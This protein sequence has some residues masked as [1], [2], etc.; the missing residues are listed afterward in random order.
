MPISHEQYMRHPPHTPWSCHMP[1]NIVE[2]SRKQNL[3]LPNLILTSV[4]SMSSLWSSF[5]T[6][7]DSRIISNNIVKNSSRVFMCC[8]SITFRIDPGIIIRQHC[9]VLDHMTQIF[10]SIV[11]VSLQDDLLHL[12]YV[13]TECIS[14][15][16]LVPAW[17]GGSHNLFQKNTNTTKQQSRSCRKSS[18]SVILISFK[19]KHSH[20]HIPRTADLWENSW[21]LCFQISNK[22]YF[23]LYFHCPDV[24]PCKYKCPDETNLETKSITSSCNNPNIDPL[25]TNTNFQMKQ[26]WRT[27]CHKFLQ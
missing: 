19:R 26:I 4:W 2:F 10:K 27:K 21:A 24:I 7:T 16:T 23:L 6:S 20:H 22:S 15:A 14:V 5:L 25:M 3:N 11:H 13:P 18:T 17:Y 9:G 1:F 12:F 8:I